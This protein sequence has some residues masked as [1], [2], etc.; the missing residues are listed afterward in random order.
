MFVQPVQF[1]QAGLGWHLKELHAV[2]YQ[3]RNNGTP[4]TQNTF[5]W[6]IGRTLPQCLISSCAEESAICIIQL[7]FS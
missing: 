3:P 1:W 5:I 7:K 2:F 6:A 4:A